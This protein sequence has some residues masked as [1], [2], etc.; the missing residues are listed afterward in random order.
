MKLCDYCL[1]ESDRLW[2]RQTREFFLIRLPPDSRKV[3]IHRGYWAACVYCRPLVAAGDWRSTAARSITSSKTPLTPR[4]QELIKDA[5][6][7][8]MQAFETPDEIEWH[9]G[10]R[11]PQLKD[12]PP[13]A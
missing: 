4:S 13:I 7:C 12:L 1:R 5:H 6:F 9:E 8:V 11:G 10:E 3:H 2:I